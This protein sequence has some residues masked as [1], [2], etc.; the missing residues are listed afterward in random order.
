MFSVSAPCWRLAKQSP[1]PPVPITLLLEAYGIQWFCW[2]MEAC[3]MKHF[4]HVCIDVSPSNTI[5][6]YC[7]AAQIIND[8][9]VSGLV[10]LVHAS[11]AVQG[12]GRSRCDT[13]LIRKGA[14][15]APEQLSQPSYGMHSKSL[16]SLYLHPLI[17]VVY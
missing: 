2:C 11:P 10:D 6:V 9:F 13:V 7:K 3:I 4:P 5:E 17:K 1:L 12:I 8:A 15:I 16:D 14:A